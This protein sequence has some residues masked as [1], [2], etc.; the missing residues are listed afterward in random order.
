MRPATAIRIKNAIAVDDLVVL[1]LEQGKV[2]LSTKSLLQLLYKLLRI[3]MSV[4]ANCQDL[5]SFLFFL[6]QK[7][8][9]LPELLC[10]VRSPM[11][12]IKNQDYILLIPKVRK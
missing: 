11:A 4:N 9:Q 1:V 12:A 7:A 2:E 10:A 5:N 3:L 8:L 6:S